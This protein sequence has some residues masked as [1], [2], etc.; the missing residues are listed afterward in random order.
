MVLAA[1]APLTHG[2]GPGVVVA[3]ASALALAFLYAVYSALRTPPAVPPAGGS[4][5]KP[6]P[7]G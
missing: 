5:A 2:D 6:H 4:G 1:G 3:I 7:P